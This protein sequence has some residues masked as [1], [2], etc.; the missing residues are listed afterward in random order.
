MASRFGVEMVASSAGATSAYTWLKV[1]VVDDMERVMAASTL[2][3]LLLGLGCVTALP[4]FTTG[5][6]EWVGELSSNDN[7]VLRQPPYRGDD[8]SIAPLASKSLSA[9]CTADVCQNSS[10]I[11]AEP[12]GG[13]TTSDVKRRAPGYAWVSII[14]RTFWSV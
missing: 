4:T 3:A 5:L 9:F 1:P 12:C 10:D 8:G 13:G 6:A 14:R 11:E 2:P 7:V